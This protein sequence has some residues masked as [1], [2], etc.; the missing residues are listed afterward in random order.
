MTVA[1]AASAGAWSAIEMVARQ[2][3]G[4]VV[5][6]ILARLLAPEHFGLIAL[7]TL[8]SGLATVL[9]QGGLTLA[10]VQ[11]QDTSHAEESA[12]FWCN[13]A[14]GVVFAGLI[15]L[16]A[17]V[18]ANFYGYPTLRLLMPVAAAQVVLG[19]LGAVQTA[20][21]T[22]QLQFDKLTKTGVVAAILSGVAGIGAALLGWGV[23]ALAVQ[24]L[25]QA[26][27]SSV[28]LWIVSDWRPSLRFRWRDLAP[29]YR[30]GLGISASSALEVL[31]SQGFALLIGK[32]HGAHDLGLFNRALATQ[33]LP[34]TILSSIV[35][36]VAL[37]L[38]SARLDDPPALK[39]GLRLSLGIS[40]LI[41]TPMVAGLAV[42][43]DLIIVCLFGEKWSPAAPILTILAVAGSLLPYHVL[44]LQLLL[45]H[46]KS[47]EFLRIE[48]QKKIIGIGLAALGSIFGIVGLAWALVVGAFVSLLLNS[49][50]AKR[51]IDY[52]IVEQIWDNRGII[53]ATLA[54]AGLVLWLKEQLDL[55]PWPELLVL[56]AAGFVTYCAISLVFRLQSFREAV[57]I[58][59]VL[60]VRRGQ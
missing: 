39:R 6:I 27:I 53:G 34:G 38:F 19:S 60:L 44:N 35:S 24:M 26:F 31:Y 42:L 46:G 2:G 36:R 8:F 30:F 3:I 48:V 4:F 40:M 58:G 32:L 7:L 51:L 41:S 52:G 12:V 16:I 20:L 14:A 55:E 43:S 13:L 28:L 9:V 47:D 59:R 23:W 22:K 29:L 1:R 25:V 33:A 45:A 56:S 5:S 17:P 15:I 11:R 18:V 21:L 50:P 57:D 37:P 10:L 49:A 54:M